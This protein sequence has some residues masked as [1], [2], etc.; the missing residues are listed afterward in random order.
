M[1][2][3]RT[4]VVALKT[5]RKKSLIVTGALVALVVLFFAEEHFRGSWQL[6]RYRKTLIAQGEKLSIAECLPAPVPED[7]NAFFALRNASARQ[8][9]RGLSDL[10]PPTF[11]F[12]TPGKVMPSLTLTQW[13]HSSSSKRSPSNI[14][15][16]V[17]EQQR[18]DFEE[19]LA[20]ARAALRKPGFD[21]RLPYHRGFNIAMSHVTQLKTI[22][23]QFSALTVMDLHAG[24]LDAALNNLDDLLRL[25]QRMAAEP[26]IIS[27]LVRNALAAIAFNATWLALHT[28]GW[29]DPQLAR[30]QKVWE[31][32]EMLTPMTRALEM[33]RAIVV[34]S[35]EQMSESGGQAADLFGLIQGGGIGAGSAGTNAFHSVGQFIDYLG[36]H[37]EELLGRNVLLPV[38]Q[39]TWA[40]QDELNYLQ[41][42]QRLVDG[43]RAAAKER[44]SHPNTKAVREVS[45][46][47]YGISGLGRLRHLLTSQTMP[48][49]ENTM[50]RSI[51]LQ[52]QRELALAAIALQRY[53]LRHGKPAADL[54]ALVPEFLRELPRDYFAAAS[55]RYQ[56]GGRD[57]FLLYSLGANE[58][59]DG[60]SARPTEP[61]SRFNLQNG[62]DLVWPRPASTA[63]IEAFEAKENPRR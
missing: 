41:L 48:S 19:P 52:V 23:M 10:A 51:I 56:P 50:S 60:G 59:D 47:V 36:E 33:E 53:E 34:M 21:A 4:Y 42:M 24:H 46:K 55:L 1:S 5:S 25:G 27:Q 61:G 9:G 30:L 62:L 32:Q 15:W 2:K 40:Q 63:E 39:F 11:R 18:K 20:E 26:I 37:H 58:T 16:A 29:T 14:T 57:E 35:Y 38:W 8:P 49:M 3:L 13:Q 7:D 28:P 12:A 17:F 44:S 45:A 22:G 54:P 43:G 6:A 31:E